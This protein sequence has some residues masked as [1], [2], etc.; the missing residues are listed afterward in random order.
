[1]AI[2]DLPV[3]ICRRNLVP[4]NPT[5]EEI[6]NWLGLNEGVFLSIPTASMTGAMLKNGNTSKL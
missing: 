4:R 3:L 6:T 1:V 2:A 5:N